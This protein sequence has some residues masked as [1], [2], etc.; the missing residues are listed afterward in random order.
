[1]KRIIY[2]LILWTVIC[3]TVLAQENRNL[4]ASSPIVFTLQ[5]HSLSMPF[6]NMKSNF[7]NVGLGIGTELSHSG[8]SQNWTQS[9]ML[10]WNRNKTIGNGI[11][12]YTQT[13][14]RADLFSDTFGEIKMGIGYQ[15]LYRPTPSF[16]LVDGNWTNVGRRGKGMMALPINIGFGQLHLS[17]NGAQAPFANY[18]WML[19]KGYA[20]TIPLVPQSAFIFGT[21]T[22]FN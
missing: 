19:L 6:H 2:G 7:S 22:H 17:S 8:K 15:Y 12:L 3:C 1:M 18:Q 21:R 16:K 4:Y 13:I 11:A 9:F 5:F 14:A 20:E 10:V